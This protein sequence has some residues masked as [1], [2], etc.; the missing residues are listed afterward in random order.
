MELSNMKTAI[1]Q[2]A[3]TGPLESLV[4]ML[5][6]VGYG[7]YLPNDEIKRE[8]RSLG[9]DNI[10]DI[11]G[12]VANWGY[13]Q[14]MALPVAG[15]EM[16]DTCDLYVD[17]KG[18]RNGP[19]I[20]NRWPRLKDKTLWYRING[21]KPEHV[22]RADGF[23]CGDEVNPPCPILTPNQWYRD[24]PDFVRA[25]PTGLFNGRAYACWP[26]FHRINDH[27]LRDRLDPST[28]HQYSPP[29]TLVHNLVGWGYGALMEPMR[30][31]GI[32]LH[33]V[34]APD[35]LI[36]HHDIPNLLANT[37]CMVHLKS[38][39][40]PG[41]SLYEALASACPVV[42]S[43]RLIWRNRMEQLLIPG[44]TCLAFDRI[45]HQGITD[46]D[47]VNCVKE[48]GDAIR[49]LS[50]PDYNKQIGQ[51][52]QAKLKSLLWPGDN[53]VQSFREYMTRHFK[54]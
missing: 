45:G 48:V 23:D 19:L 36:Q 15:I 49:F 46:E 38:S 4:D 29:I 17:V 16:M 40:A 12:L 41:Y 47:V 52:G 53:G 1:L 18:L 5:S 44:E 32:K 20:W 54:L 27:Q 9:C 21:G 22:I 3:D 37:L 51:A 14:P 42:C 33:G 13:E 26:P 34:G 28:G 8:L 39:D 10:T 6:A 30:S 31:L 35:G 50:L 43:R 11:S 25:L 2:C 24:D 7:C